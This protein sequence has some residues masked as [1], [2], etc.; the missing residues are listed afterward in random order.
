MLGWEVLVLSPQ[1]YA[2]DIEVEEFNA[3]QSF[4]V[5]RLSRVAGAPLK[6]VY[7]FRI[8]SA[9]VRHFRPDI[10]LASGTTA[11]WL[12]MLMPRSWGLPWVAIG[13]GLEFGLKGAFAQRLTRVAFERADAAVCVSRYTQAKMISRGI[14]PKRSV[15]ITNGADDQSFYP[16]SSAEQDDCRASMGLG[17]G[18]I[19]LSVGHVSERKGHDLVISALP[20][21]LERRPLTRY[22]I[23]GLPTE[24]DRLTN[25]AQRLGVADHVSFLGRVDRDE[26]RVLYGTSDVHVMPSRHSRSGDFEGYGIAVVEAALCGTPSVVSRNSGLEEAIVAEQTGLSVPEEDPAEIA[27]AVL[28]LLGDEA[29]RVAL[30]QAARSRALEDQTWESRAVLFKDLLQGLTKAEI[31]RGD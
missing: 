6:L 29:F 21:I 16:P 18:Q 11:V 9:E 25:L 14:S 10:V 20:A 15:V 7:R 31:S 2:E 27:K 30:A 13:H 12:A 23:A 19:L 26:L 3:K 5:R 28:R 1:D 17:Q 22:V 4:Q 8:L 24:R